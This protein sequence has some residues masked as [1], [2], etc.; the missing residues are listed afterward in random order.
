MID[1]SFK[2]ASQLIQ[3][4]Q[5]YCAGCYPRYPQ[6]T[7]EEIFDRIVW[8]HLARHDAELTTRGFWTATPGLFQKDGGGNLIEPGP[9]LYHTLRQQF[10]EQL[11]DYYALQMQAK[12]ES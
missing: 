11:K 5:K 7:R 8:S 6:A 10:Q 1:V 3:A 2:P 9:R 4:A 12:G